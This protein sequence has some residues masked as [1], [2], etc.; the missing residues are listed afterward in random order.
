MDFTYELGETPFRRALRHGMALWY[1]QSSPTKDWGAGVG[2]GDNERTMTKF[3]ADRIEG[4]LGEVAFQRLLDEEFGVESTVDWDVYGDIEET[5]DADLGGIGPDGEY[6]P[7]VGFDVKKTKPRNLW[8]AVRASIW[9]DHGDADPFV[10][11]KLDL[12]DRVGLEPWADAGT[13]PDDDPEFERAVA[14]WCER[15]LPIS[16]SVVGYAEK[17]DFTDFFERGDRLY[18]PGGGFDIGPR[19]KTDNRGIP[20]EDLRADREAWNELVERVVE[21]TPVDPRPL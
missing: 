10:L 14:E 16:V 11:C 19:L 3:V 8:L 7:G 12:P 6:P 1:D 2:S 5:D 9:R 18:H 17:R 4:K 15:H 13:Y 21:G 20:V